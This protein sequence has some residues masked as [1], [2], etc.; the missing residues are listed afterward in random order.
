MF[1]ILSRL[2]WPVL[3][4]LAAGLF[5][6]A[7]DGYRAGLDAADPLAA[8]RAAAMAG[9]PGL[10]LT[11][12]ALLRLGRGR[13]GRRRA[14]WDGEDAPEFGWS[15]GPAAR[16][17]EAQ[18]PARYGTVPLPRHIVWSP[19]EA[20]RA[21]DAAGEK[22]QVGST[23]AAPEVARSSWVMR[24]IGRMTRR[25]GLAAAAYVVVFVLP[26]GLG[27]LV[28]EEVIGR[29][30]PALKSTL[31]WEAP[32]AVE[33]PERVSLQAA[34]AVAAAVRMAEAESPARAEPTLVAEA[35]L[36][37][38]GMAAR[39]MAG[40]RAAVAAVPTGLLAGGVGGLGLLALAA[41][42]VRRRWGGA[43][44]AKADPWARLPDRLR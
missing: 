20:V 36:L 35:G 27:G 43:A 5:W 9:L 33:R 32:V 31:G 4:L 3:A 29:M 44:V 23:L 2:P 17:A 7:Q 22:V 18:E 39:A 6:L 30:M 37:P 25:C 11:G 13:G 15:P 12:A 38:D 21:R 10:I 40:L 42:L 26:I 19:L 28:S 41:L 24:G 34:G 14:S 1:R 16:A 8:W